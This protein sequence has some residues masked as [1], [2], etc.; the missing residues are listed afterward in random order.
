METP[1]RSNNMYSRTGA[2]LGQDAKVSFWFEI[3]AHWEVYMELSMYDRE[4]EWVNSWR[5]Y[6]GMLARRVT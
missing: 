2:R 4:T 1:I 6:Q 3:H 5:K